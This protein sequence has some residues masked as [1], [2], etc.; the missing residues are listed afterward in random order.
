[1][2]NID[3]DKLRLKRGSDAPAKK[4]GVNLRLWL[5]VGLFVLFILYLMWPKT[6]EV[7]VTQVVTAWPS[8][9][10]QVLNATGYVGAQRS[11]A[12]A[13]KGTGRIEWIG[14]N[15]GDAVLEGAIVAR[16]EG[17]DLAANH[18]A[19]VANTA[20]AEAGL[21]SAKND[22][23][24][25]NRNL[26]R[27][28]VL[29][30]R[31]LVSLF[32]LQE[33]KSRRARTAASVRSAEASVTAAQANEMFAKSKLDA[34]EI[35]APFDGTVI[36]LFA[37][38][39]D[40][41]TPVSSAADSKGAVM[42]IAD[43]TT[44]EVAADVSESSL[45]DIRSGQPC[46]IVLDAFPDRRYRGEVRTIVPTINKSSATATAK[47]R[48]L[49][50]AENILPGM[51]AR[52]AFLSRPVR[53]EEQKPVLAVSPSAIVEGESG[54][55][56]LR[57]GEDARAQAVPV[58]AGVMLGGVRRVEGDLKAGDALV[59]EPGDRVDDKD[60]VKLATES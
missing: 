30:K 50:T 37:N 41:V 35:K 43:L 59:L 14:V 26:E 9:E 12:V 3:L 27:T 2:S 16:L 53:S 7:Q 8:Q 38:V 6:V 13:S 32:Q 52:V 48:F 40:I 11:A 49:S 46:E 60:R 56:V 44:L 22:L 42:V 10:F 47:V 31:K 28:N 55:Y 45:S 58:K 15:E 1:M 54:S 21:A 5:P 34:S 19:A 25:A 51:S 33:A 17:S 39:G 20:V 4:Q 57:I 18:H 29:Y 23:V 36:S 24:D